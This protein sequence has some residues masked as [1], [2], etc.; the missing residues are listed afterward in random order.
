VGAAA[1]LTAVVRGLD[2][3]LPGAILLVAAYP[4]VLLGL[5]FYL[6]VERARLLAAGR[7]LYLTGRT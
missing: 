7:R 2:V 1:A 3:P 6:P 5:G 4:L